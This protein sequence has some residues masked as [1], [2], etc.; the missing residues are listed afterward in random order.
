MTNNH[1]L[2]PTRLAE[3]TTYLNSLEDTPATPPVHKTTPDE[4]V[5]NLVVEQPRLD[6]VTEVLP[7]NTVERK[8]QYRDSTRKSGPRRQ[9]RR[10]DHTCGS[11][12]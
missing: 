4:G 8:I 1:L 9:G 2:T 7:F 3:F 5:K 11:D 10:E 12:D 6:V